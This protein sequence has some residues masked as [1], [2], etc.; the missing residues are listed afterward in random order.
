MTPVLP[1]AL[2]L[3][4]AQVSQY[5]LGNQLLAS[6]RLAEAEAAYRTHLKS[7][8]RHVEAL[9]NLGTVLSRRENFP[10]AIA[11]LRQA[12]AL[13]PDLAPLHLNLGLAYFKAREW[14][15]AVN[16]FETFLKS[17]PN[18][19]QSL[20]LR[21]LSLLELERYTDAAQAFEA[22]LPGDASVQLGLATAYLKSDR[23]AQAQQILGPLLEQGNSPEV[24]LTVGQALFVEDRLDESLATL[25]KARTLAPQLPTLGLHI[26]AIY[27]R[28]KDTATAVAEWRKELKLHPTSA[29]AKFTLGAAI[30]MSGGDKMEAERLLRSS[31]T[32]KPRHARANYQ[33]GKLLWQTRRSPEAVTC[34]ER[35]TSADPSYREAHFQLANIYQSLGRKTEAAREFATVKSLASKELSRQQDLFSE[36]P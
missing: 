3:L 36:Q 7:N 13:R 11:T 12:L 16:E 33:L 14:Q 10:A 30:A 21:A 34:L 19:R 9:A 27:W 20:Q 18:H 31:L 29:E 35:A 24:L 26:G 22:L 4:F 1:L 5:D 25:E 23:V 15:P 2:A 32:A 6:G 8:P 28:R 17:Q